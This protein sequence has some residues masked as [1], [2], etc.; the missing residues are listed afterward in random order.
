[1]NNEI[2]KIAGIAVAAIIGIGLL[3]AFWPVVVG[4]LAL[5]GLG[6]LI[7]WFIE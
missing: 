2:L 7:Y 1:M 3:A 6:F 4:I 5:T